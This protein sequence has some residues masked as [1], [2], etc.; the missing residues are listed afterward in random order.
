MVRQHPRFPASFSAPSSTRVTSIRLTSRWISRAKA[1]GLNP[2]RASAGMKVDLLSLSLKT[3][4]RSSFKRHRT[5]VG[6]HGIGIEFSPS[7]HPIRNGWTAPSGTWKPEPVT[8]NT[9]PIRQLINTSRA[10]TREMVPDSCFCSPRLGRDDETEPALSL[11]LTARSTRLRTLY[12]ACVYGSVGTRGCWSN[13]P[14]PAS[15]ESC[16]QY[17]THVEPRDPCAYGKTTLRFACHGL[18]EDMPITVL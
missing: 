10:R 9:T 7:L 16:S 1:V 5:L 17:T 13:L 8:A 2:L 11:R 12:G 15:S 14:T 4:P 18:L 6:V 3:I